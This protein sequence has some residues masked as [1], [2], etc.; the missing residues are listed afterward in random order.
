M[1]DAGH[2]PQFMKSAVNEILKFMIFFILSNRVPGDVGAANSAPKNVY[3]SLFWLLFSGVTSPH[4]AAA[5][6]FLRELPP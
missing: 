2:T 3:P 5:Y 4:G 6:R 1:C